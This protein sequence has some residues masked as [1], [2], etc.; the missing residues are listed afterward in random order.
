LCHLGKFFGHPLS[1]PEQKIHELE[2]GA[3]PPISGQ[4]TVRREPVTFWYRNVD[5]SI[6][7]CLKLEIDSRGLPFFGAR[8]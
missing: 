8:L 3:L 7:H 2:V 1:V 5:E 4:V 6:Q